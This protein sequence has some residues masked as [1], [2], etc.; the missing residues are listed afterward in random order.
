MGYL[1]TTL[2]VRFWAV[3]FGYKTL[4]FKKYSKKSNKNIL[5]SAINR[6]VR[7][8]IIIVYIHIFFATIV[9]SKLLN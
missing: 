7:N 9:M 3:Y 1:A 2:R 4:V 8:S 5:F 6:S